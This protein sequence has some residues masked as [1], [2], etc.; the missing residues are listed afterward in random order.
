MTPLSLA[1]A[2][3]FWT[4]PGVAP[5]GPVGSD[6]NPC[7]A[8]PR[9]PDEVYAARFSGDWTPGEICDGD[10]IENSGARNGVA[11]VTGPQVADFDI[12]YLDASRLAYTVRD[13]RT[14]IPARDYGGGWLEPLACGNAVWVIRRVESPVDASVVSEYMRGGLP[15]VGPRTGGGASAHVAPPHI[16][17]S[18]RPGA[19]TPGE[20]HIPAVP[21]PA[22]PL[23]QTLALF[24]GALAILGAMKIGRDHG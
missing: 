15:S 1:F 7:W 13:G 14:C 21:I 10:V 20:S 8:A 22:V 3:I 23:P 19:E 24:L 17:E 2:A 9:V 12:A 4:T 6:A 18:D 5:C 16:F 11:F